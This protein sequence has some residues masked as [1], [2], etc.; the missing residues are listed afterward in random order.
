MTL[1]A[2]L[3]WQIIVSLLLP[4]AMAVGLSIVEAHGPLSPAIRKTVGVVPPYVAAI[5]IVFGLF[6]TRL[7]TDVWEKA[8][9]AHQS[10][11]AEDDAMRAILSLGNV[12]GV[13]SSILPAIKA[14]AAAASREVPYSTAP[15]DAREMTAKA[16]EALLSAIVALKLPDSA[17]R[18]AFESAATDL[19]RARGRRL[20]VADDE[21]ATIKWISIL[22]L[23]LLTQI[24]IV[25]VHVGSPRAM[26]AAL[27]IFTVAFT[28]CIVIVAI[29]D[30]PFETLFAN[31]PAATFA[32]LQTG[33]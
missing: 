23:G 4:L 14:Y 33:D 6:A 7:T 32:H 31:E 9:T 13:H 28:F 19:R 2:H 18:G 1:I 20:Y 26:R 8:N 29:F 27:G 16:Y 15:A 3:D 5:T 11:Q 10:I 30:Q 17:T 21:T 12:N 22:F 25:F 24:T